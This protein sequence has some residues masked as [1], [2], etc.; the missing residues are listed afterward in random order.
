MTEVEFDDQA[1]ET[2]VALY[3]SD[4]GLADA[5]DAIVDAIERDPGAAEVRRHLIRPG[6]V[7]A[8][9][10]RHPRGQDDYMLLWSLENDV[11][12]VLHIGPN[13]LLA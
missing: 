4:P 2:L 12:T 3:D 5:V 6:K 7:F 9:R 1:H 13:T 11:P 10:V 8:L